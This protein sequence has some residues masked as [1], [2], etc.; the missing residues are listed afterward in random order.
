MV[1]SGVPSTFPGQPCDICKL[2]ENVES[3]QVEIEQTGCCRS[4]FP[5]KQAN[6]CKACKDNDWRINGKATVNG[7]L[8]YFNLK[9]HEY[10]TV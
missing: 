7:G 4:A 2:T 10:R 5:Y 6:L 1:W 9:T 3:V 8:R